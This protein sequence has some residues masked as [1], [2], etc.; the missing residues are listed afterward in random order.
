MLHAPI[1]VKETGSS[2]APIYAAAIGEQG[3]EIHGK[4]QPSAVSRAVKMV[5]YLCSDHSME[6]FPSIIT[7]LTFLTVSK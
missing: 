7:S 6:K 5:Q 4:E 1:M 3:I 2:S